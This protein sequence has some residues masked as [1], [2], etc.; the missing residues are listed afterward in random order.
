MK[1]V[2][3][4]SKA[5]IPCVILSLVIIVSGAFRICTKGINLGLDFKPGLIEEFKIAPTAIAMNYT[6][7]AQVSVQ[8]NAQGVSL[9]VAGVG[10]ENTTF[11][12]PYI[13]YTNLESMV[14]GFNSVEGVKATLKTVDGKESAQGLFTNSEKSAT[15]S[16]DEAFNLYIPD[17]EAVD[18]TADDIREIFGEDNVAVKALGVPLDNHFQIRVGDD[19]SD[20]EISKKIQENI[21]NK[22][23]EKF[24]A[25]NYAI[26][27][28]DFIGAQFSGKLVIS[29]IV[30][31]LLSLILIWLYATI[32]FKWD[33]ALGAILAIIHDALIMI[34]FMAWT[35]ME[36]TSTSIAAILTIIG[37]SINDTVV[38]LDRVRENIKLLK[39]KKFS[40]ILDISQ[41]ELLTRTMI[42]T[43]TT[44]LAV[45]SLFIFTTGNMKDFA[46][47]LIVGLISGIYSTIFIAGAFIALVRRKWQPSD[48]DKKT[49]VISV[50][51]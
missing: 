26:V 24:G 22:L 15:L 45:I 47:A 16:S 2:I 51:E 7:S 48:E 46:L 19:G 42:T 12:F 35:Q 40:S 10:A 30:T 50:E 17:S 14:A 3:H 20:P 29:S 1:K 6:G 49:Q 9:V 32:R 33:F 27:K 37:Y 28:T 43:I 11:E 5:F 13:K 21:S 36:F 23:A 4:F 8:V 41:S 44:L 34:A 39:V 38:V 18:I 25:D 31:V